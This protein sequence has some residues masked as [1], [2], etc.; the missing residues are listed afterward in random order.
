M[1]KKILALSIFT[2]VCAISCTKTETQTVTVTEQPVVCDVKGVYSGSSVS[3][4]GAASSTVYYLEDNNFAKGSTSVGGTFVTFGGYRNTCDSV[5]L[6]VR[7]T[8]NSSYYLLKGKL[9]DNKTK[10]SGTFVNL[11]TPSDNG[12]FALIKQ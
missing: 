2:I 5:I 11:T 6:S 4:T 12:T 10:I 1:R 7:Y 9:L 8:S 3:T